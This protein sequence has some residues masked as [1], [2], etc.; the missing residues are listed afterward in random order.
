M[1]FSHKTGFTIR[2]TDI[3]LKTTHTHTKDILFTRMYDNNSFDLPAAFD[4]LY[5]ISWEN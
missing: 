4:R 2:A 3:Y 1:D 5:F